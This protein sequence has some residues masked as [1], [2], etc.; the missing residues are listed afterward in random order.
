MACARVHLTQPSGPPHDPCKTQERLCR[1]PTF[2]MIMSRPK[3]AWRC[4]PEFGSHAEAR[5][6]R[7]QRSC[8]RRCPRPQAPP[9]QASTSGTPGQAA[10]GERR[11]AHNKAVHLGPQTRLRRE[12]EGQHTS[13]LRLVADVRMLRPKAGCVPETTGSRATVLPSAHLVHVDL[14]MLWPQ[15]LL[16]GSIILLSCSST[17]VKPQQCLATGEMVYGFKSALDGCAMPPAE[18][19]LGR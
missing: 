9:T 14:A 7:A 16:Q 13:L 18:G 3:E 15:H 17:I 2:R 6:A 1:H 8:Q 5:A 10:E 11:S 12:N 19:E 4:V